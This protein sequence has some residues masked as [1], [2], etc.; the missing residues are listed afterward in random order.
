[1]QHIVDHCTACTV[2]KTAASPQ[3]PAQ[4]RRLQVILVHGAFGFGAEWEPIVAEIRRDRDASF[5]VFEWKG[6]FRNLTSTV[7]NL[8]GVVQRALDEEPGAQD[9]LVLA[10]SAG[11]PI[12]TR[13][14]LAAKVPEGRRL[15]VAEID[16]P[17]FINGK[18]FFADKIAAAPVLPTGVERIVYVADNP[19][20]R[21][22]PD[23]PPRIYLGKKVDHNAAVAVAGLPLLDRLR[24][25]PKKPE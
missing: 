12:A 17:T 11:G 20:K 16:S 9:V 10:H 2:V 21:E 13:A 19:P 8:S 14:A 7:A 15:L 6:P 3:P 18:P 25:A 23:A 5:V 4:P 1:M 24:V 22:K